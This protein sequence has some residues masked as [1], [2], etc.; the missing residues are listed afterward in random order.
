MKEITFK[1]LQR[2]MIKRKRTV[3]DLVDIF[4]GKLEENRSFFERVMSCQWRNPDTGR[5]EDRSAVVI[6]YRSV[7]EFYL[8]EV[9]YLKDSEQEQERLAT[10]RKRGPMSEERRQAQIKHLEKARAAKSVMVQK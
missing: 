2:L 6:P 3:D 7:I 10:N 1:D 4:H 9:E 5:H 8:K